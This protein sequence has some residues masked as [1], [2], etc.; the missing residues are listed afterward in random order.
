MTKEITLKKLILS[1]RA[2]RP[3][4]KA[5]DVTKLIIEKYPEVLNAFVVS[6]LRDEATKKIRAEV[7]AKLES[8]NNKETAGQK[9]MRQMEESNRRQGERLREEFL[10][11]V[12]RDHVT[13][14]TEDVSIPSRFGV[15]K[16]KESTWPPQK[17]R[18]E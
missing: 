7:K 17:K 15:V 10:R 12:S 4:I 1:I 3:D 11:V 18:G 16:V 13:I 5:G 2:D 14:K 8:R 6:T 9:L